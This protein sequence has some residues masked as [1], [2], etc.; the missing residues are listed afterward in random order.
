MGPA[1]NHHWPHNRSGNFVRDH[2]SLRIITDA[3]CLN[4]FAYNKGYFKRNQPSALHFYLKNPTHFVLFPAVN[5][6]A[7]GSDHRFS[8]EPPAAPGADPPTSV[9]E[10]QKNTHATITACYPLSYLAIG[11]LR[12]ERE[13]EGS[14]A[15]AL[16]VRDTC[17]RCTSIK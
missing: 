16:A 14:R 11:R 7:P 13:P 1:G 9:N 17:G 10:R 8:P 12:G 15:G 3:F 5:G 2:Y 4:D 6:S